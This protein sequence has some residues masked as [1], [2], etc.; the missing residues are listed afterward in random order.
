MKFIVKSQNV[1]IINLLREIGYHFQGENEERGEIVLYH[2]LSSSDYPR[3]HLYLK[4]DED[5]LV[6]N[7]HLD[8]KRPVY[9]GAPAHSAEYGGEIVEREAERIK[10][11]LGL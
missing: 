6:F 2:P 1:N 8:Q 10:K 5:N 9:K 3:F 7:L 11:A 4:K